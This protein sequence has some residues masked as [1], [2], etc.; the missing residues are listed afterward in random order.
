VII[1]SLTKRATSNYMIAVTSDPEYA[2]EQARRQREARKVGTGGRYRP[3]AEEWDTR[4]ELEA[5]LLD[6]LGEAVSLL[7]DMPTAVKR[8]GKPP[9]P[10]PRP[11]SAIE[12]AEEALAEEHME[13]IIADVEDGYVSDDEYRRMAAEAEA[14]MAAQQQQGGAHAV[15]ST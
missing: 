2:L 8:R 7:G 15:A 1:E 9:K 11:F 3:P 14:E 4:A 12:A 5:R 6:R 13:E 10:F